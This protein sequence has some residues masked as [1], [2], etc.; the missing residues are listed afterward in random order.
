MKLISR[1]TYIS[2]LKRAKGTPDI[3]VLTGVRRSGKSKLLS[4]FAQEI[5]NTEED[6]NVIQIDFNLLEFEQLREYHA[7]HAYIEDRYIANSNNYVFIDEVQMCHSFELAINSLH[8]SEKYDIYITGSNAFLMS[9]DLA[10]L[11]T[12]RT[13]E[14][15]VFPFSLLE[16]MKYFELEDPNYAF[17]QYLKI[18]GMPG[19]YIY[20]SQVDKNEYLNDVFSTLIV[21]DI[22]Q[23]YGIREPRL[24]SKIVNFMIDNISNITSPAKI[25]NALLE[26]NIKTNGKT[27]GSYISYLCDAFAF[28]KVRRYDTRGKRYLAS[29]NKYYLVDH[30]FRYALLGT[31]NIDYGRVYENIVAIEL[32]RRGYEIY[33]GVL[34]EKEIDFVAIK[35]SEK[36]YIQVADNISDEITFK[37]EYE[38]LLRIRDAYSKKIIANTN[39]EVYTFEGIEIIDLSY[40]LT[41]AS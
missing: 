9:S 17:N 30:S 3:K 8:A 13:F 34:Y 4:M 26:G 10:T 38:P 40:W 21:R 29:G 1:E 22:K 6:A 33:A 12:G 28:Y 39:H 11:F 20:D 37:R 41:T 24:L 23:K 25:A 35:Q 31:R 18:G 19:S 27:V 16:F 36:I 32:M 5:K 15:P 7:L 14:I 2:K